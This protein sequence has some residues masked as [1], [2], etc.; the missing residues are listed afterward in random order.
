ML[1]SRTGGIQSLSKTLVDQ[2]YPALRA[3]HIGAVILS[4]LLFF[5]RGLL[6]NVFGVTAAMAAPV[7]WVS[8]VIDTVLLLAALSLMVVVRQY[9]F[10][11]GWLTAKVLLLAVYIGLGSFAL[12]RGRTRRARTLYWI[13]AVAVF[14]MIVSIA[15]S[16]H[17]LG[18]FALS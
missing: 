3:I 15:R 16:H 12:K 10:V 11:D 8:Y 4:G 6:L 18:L 13:A 14:L 7:R 2:F 9:P 1:S 17:P 5:A